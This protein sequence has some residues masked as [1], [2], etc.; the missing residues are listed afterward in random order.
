MFRT[1]ERR[2]SWKRSPGTPAAVQARA[3]GPRKSSLGCPFLWKDVLAHEQRA[4]HPRE[5]PLPA[6]LHQL[7]QVA[8]ERRLLGEAN[9]GV[10][11]VDHGY[12]ADETW[13]P[14]GA[15]GAATV[16]GPAGPAAGGARGGAGR[17]SRDI[18]GHGRRVLRVRRA[19]A[20]GWLRRPQEHHR[21]PDGARG[22]ADI[23]CRCRRGVRPGEGARAARRSGAA[24]D[25]AAQR[26]LAP[27]CARD[28][29]AAGHARTGASAHPRSAGHASAAAARGSREWSPPLRRRPASGRSAAR[30]SVRVDG[31]VVG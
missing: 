18:R 17:P 9:I 8:H 25:E 3:H 4:R 10:L 27:A 21:V 12:R 26:L 5:E 11:L 15:G 24:R 7:G 19:G 16:S 28:R 14:G 22:A 2:R 13:S 30:T 31:Q 20:G 1:A 23:A 6:A 29:G